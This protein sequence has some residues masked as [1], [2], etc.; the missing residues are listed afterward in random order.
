M[1]VSVYKERKERNFVLLTTL[2]PSAII[3]Q[4]INEQKYSYV[5]SRY[6]IP[7]H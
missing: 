2:I 1:A 5:K 4:K 7:Y 3:I 6:E